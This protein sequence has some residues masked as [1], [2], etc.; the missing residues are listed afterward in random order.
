VSEP[1]VL[2][3]RSRRWGHALHSPRI[4]DAQKPQTRWQKLMRRKPETYSY[5][6]CM[7]HSTPLPNEG[8]IMLVRMESGRTARFKVVEVRWFGDPRDMFKIKRA[9]F[10]GYA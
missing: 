4:L 5:L 6:D 2:D 1:R 7:G 9:D 10:V 8:D 3:F